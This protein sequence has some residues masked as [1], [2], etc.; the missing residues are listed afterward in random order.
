MAD[1][2]KERM[3]RSAVYLL[4]REGYQGASFSAVLAHS[5]A[6]RGSVYHHFPGGKDELVAAAVEATLQRGLAHLDEYRGGSLATVLKAIAGY[7]R[8]VLERSDCAAGCPIV[9][10]S[11]GA[12]DPALRST[13][14]T[15][16]ER[17]RLHYRE[18]LEE[19]GV[20][21]KRSAEVAAL[22]LSG[23]E[24]AMHLARAQRSLDV[25]D[26][27]SRALLRSAAALAA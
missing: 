18:V 20:P 16:F 26:Q 14:A 19:S 4:A 15:A 24:G 13:V 8:G 5:G 9:A 6:P 25:F 11:I 2:V 12:T 1:D 10:T 21:R 3:I 17:W 23:Y 27:A 7:W 22:L